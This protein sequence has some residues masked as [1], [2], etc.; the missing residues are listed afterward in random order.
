MKRSSHDI[1]EELRPFIQ[2]RTSRKEKLRA[3]VRARCVEGKEDRWLVKD[4][5]VAA[6]MELA[7]DEVSARTQVS[8]AFKACGI[9]FRRP[10]G[11]GKRGGQTLAVKDVKPGVASA[12]QAIEKMFGATSASKRKQLSRILGALAV[13]EQP[14]IELVS[15]DRVQMVDLEPQRGVPAGT[16]YAPATDPRRSRRR[17]ALEDQTTVVIDQRQSERAEDLAEGIL[18]SRYGKLLFRAGHRNGETRELDDGMVPGADF[19]R[20]GRRKRQG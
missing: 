14:Q 17:A 8:S 9:R 7:V 4:E 16:G 11:G 18:R 15:F 1:A 6:L 20:N 13:H 12:I 10:G 3:E 5:L 19:I 2:A